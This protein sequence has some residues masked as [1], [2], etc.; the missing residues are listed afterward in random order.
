MLAYFYHVGGLLAG[1]ALIVY[2]LILIALVKF[3]NVT[4]TL[5]SIA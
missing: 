1:I 4:L 5:A 3:T 2:S